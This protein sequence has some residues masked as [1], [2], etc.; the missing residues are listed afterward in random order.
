MR[1]MYAW[2]YIYLISL[3]SYLYLFITRRIMEHYY[4]LPLVITL[5]YCVAKVIDSKYLNQEPD[6]PLKFV[7]RDAFWVLI[8]SLVATFAYVHLQTYI[9]EFMHVVTDT[10]VHVPVVGTT[11]IF[12]GDPGF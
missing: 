3:T 10:K 7:I 4:V 6:R 2:L 12:T 5:L 8:G 11:E 9:Q 1:Y